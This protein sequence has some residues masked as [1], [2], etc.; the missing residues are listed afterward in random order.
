MKNSGYLSILLVF[1][2]AACGGYQDE[3]QDGESQPESGWV[4]TR[5]VDDVKSMPEQKYRDVF[6]L[7]SCKKGFEAIGEFKAAEKDACETTIAGM[8]DPENYDCFKADAYDQM[9]KKEKFSCE[10]GIDGPGK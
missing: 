10:E 9:R 4:L 5:T 1:Q 8:E 7:H 2:A 3:N 6:S